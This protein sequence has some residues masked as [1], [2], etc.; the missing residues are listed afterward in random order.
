LPLDED[1]ADDSSLLGIAEYV[2]IDFGLAGVVTVSGNT[3][4]LS[5]LSFAKKFFAKIWVARPTKPFP[6]IPIFITLVRNQYY[7]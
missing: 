1:E 3:S 4:N 6:T 2:R 7:K 5:A